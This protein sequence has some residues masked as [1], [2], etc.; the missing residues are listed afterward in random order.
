MTSLQSRKHLCSQLIH[1]LMDM[2]KIE[3]EK[4]AKTANDHLKYIYRKKCIKVYE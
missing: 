2:K 4:L 1:E 3:Q